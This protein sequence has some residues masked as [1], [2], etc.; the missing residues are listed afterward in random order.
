MSEC[1]TISHRLKQSFAQVDEYG[2]TLDGGPWHGPSLLQSLAGVD[3]EQAS[4]RPIEGRH[5]IWELVNHC[6]YWMNSVDKALRGEAMESV[7]ETED[8]EGMG[9]TAEEWTRDLE[10]LDQTYARLQST[11]KGLDAKSLDTIVSSQF[12]DN[13]FRFSYRKM[14]HGVA[15]HN[16]YHAGQVSILKLKQPQ[17]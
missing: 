6:T 14:L 17:Q 4:A 13:F 3:V 1:R 7:P 5:T 10:R 16:I 15:D 12:G 9:E 2:P 11:I 8:W